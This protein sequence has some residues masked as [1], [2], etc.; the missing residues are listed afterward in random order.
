MDEKCVPGD[1]S[2]LDLLEEGG[3]EKSALGGWVYA[4]ERSTESSG[5][6][7]DADFGEFDVEDDGGEDVDASGEFHVFE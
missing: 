6:V 5:V 2:G 4:E 7:A 3:G 1:L